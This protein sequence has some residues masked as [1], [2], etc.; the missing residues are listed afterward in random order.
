MRARL[1]YRRSLIHGYYACASFID[2]QV[3]RLIA[4]IH[5]LGVHDSTITIFMG[6][7]GF[8]LGDHGL[9]GKH[10]MYEQATRVPFI[11]VDPRITPA[12]ATGASAVV[13]ELLDLFPTL[14]NLTGTAAPANLQGRSLAPLLAGP[15]AK[16][17]AADLASNTV[18]LRERLAVSQFAKNL[19]NG[20][21]FYGYSYRTFQYRYVEWWHLTKPRA[22]VCPAGVRV[23]G[24]N[25]LHGTEGM[26]LPAQV[27]YIYLCNDSNYFE[28]YDYSASNL[29]YSSYVSEK[30]NVYA[31]PVYASV[32][33]DMRRLAETHETMTTTMV[34][35]TTMSTT[36][37]TTT[38]TTTTTSTTYTTTA[39]NTTTA[40]TSAVQAP[41]IRA[42][43]TVT[44]EGGDGPRD[45]TSTNLSGAK[46]TA[47]RRQPAH[48]TGPAGI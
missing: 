31:D 7:H 18:A 43:S 10:T 8:H 4:H 16:T 37:M 11:F 12:A 5:D 40:T 22:G 32:A 2:A 15:K 1:E 36:T 9:W 24:I 25:V 46:A 38:L 17:A 23:R 35:T 44:A 26:F 39:T 27:V 33:R 13:V 19:A 48:Q 41:D 14:A 42:P 21:K 29:T 45:N 30:V 20:A 3:G 6:D 28:L 34:T 47:H